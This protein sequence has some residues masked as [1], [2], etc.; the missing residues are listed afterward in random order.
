VGR[1][2]D[3]RLF[4]FC[5]FIFQ[6]EISGFKKVDSVKSKGFNFNSKN[7]QKQKHFLCGGIRKL[8]LSE[9]VQLD[10]EMRS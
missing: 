1:L 2:K 10:K 7:I 5:Q 9:T 8:E 4:G 3:L 6:Q